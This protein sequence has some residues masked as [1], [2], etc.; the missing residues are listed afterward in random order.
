[1]AQ[2]RSDSPLG[3]GTVSSSLSGS[4]GDV[5]QARDISGGV[6]FHAGTGT[7]TPAPRQLPAD[8]HGFVGR[9]G[10]LEHLDALLTDE[11]SSQVRLV[12]IAGT[13]GAG[14]TSLAV[15][16]AHRIRARFPDGQLFVNLRGYD[17]GPPLAP[18]AAL[19]RFLRALGT[20]APAIPAGMEE[21]AELYRSLLADQKVLVVLD[22]AATVGQVRPLLPGD[23][24]CLVVVTSRSRLSGLSAR[25]GAHRVTLGLLSD[26]EAVELVT[27]ATA[28]YRDADDPAQVAELAHLCARLPLALRIAAERAA[29]RPWMPLRDLIT[30]LRGE[31]SLWDALSADDDAEADA[32]RTVFAWSYRAL[33]ATAARAFRLL[34]LH[35]GPEFGTQAAAALLAEPM[36]RTKGLLDLLTGAHLL[37]QTAITRYQFHD[38]L[39]AYAADLAHQD[40][41][42]A[43]RTSALQRIATWYLYT[44]DAAVRAIQSL[45]PSILTT[46][47][48][49]DIH[50]LA[51]ADYAAGTDWFRAEQANLLA[52][53]RV[54]AAGGLDEI[55]WQLPATVH[56]AYDA[57]GALDDWL[58]TS[59]LGLDA[60][61]RLGDRGAEAAVLQPYGYACKTARQFDQA[62]GAHQ[63]ALEIYTEL[64]DQTGMLQAANSLG[65]T[66]LRQRDLDHATACFEQTLAL[67]QQSGDL[68]WTAVALDNLASTLQEKGQHQ[69]AIALAEQALCLYQSSISDLRVRIDP[70]LTLARANRETGHMT[71]AQGYIDAAAEII[72]GGVVYLPT[73]CA[74][75]LEQ[76]YLALAQSHYDQA[77]EAFWRCINLQRSLGDRSQEAVA[78]DGLGQTLLALDRG[79][80]AA[81][82]HRTAS[83]THRSLGDPW[84]LAQSLAHFADALEGT[85]NFDEV[86][87]TRTEAVMLLDIFTD[88]TAVAL[89]ECLRSLSR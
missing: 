11:T 76:A 63:R 65:L 82:F 34:G 88:P 53:A 81:D 16:F 33:P 10:E 62:A 55:T 26:T 37:E 67:A 20:P 49:P 39:R 23:A 13:A 2:E 44:A 60:A 41:D 40:E 31:S 4:A 12:V 24:G 1:M 52:L 15:R 58:E 19:E 6:H 38:L 77:L 9:I 48:S 30:D 28:G 70:L 51:F 8:V 36:E 46:P 32:V 69:Q 57:H 42:A 54:A 35:P 84:R 72:A 61:R 29:A 75:Q 89:R 66:H 68:P 71:D 78:F 86:W 80:E 59:R 7:Q 18:Q 3:A 25:D 14:K 83:S 50:P 79:Q 74:I 5:V 87:A 17:Q 45:Y 73:E 22:N 21:R 85:G 27:A 47:P 56:P 43:E 64:G